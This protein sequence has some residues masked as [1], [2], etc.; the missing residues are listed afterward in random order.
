MSNRFEFML[1]LM[2][3][4]YLLITF[5]LSPDRKPLNKSDLFPNLC[6]LNLIDDLEV[7]C[8]YGKE[9]KDKNIHRLQKKSFA[10]EVEEDEDGCTAIIK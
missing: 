7:H 2:W 3:T 6:I 1:F 4:R 5:F 8:M 10:S 9:Y